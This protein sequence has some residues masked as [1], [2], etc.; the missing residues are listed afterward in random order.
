VSRHPDLHLLTWTIRVSVMLTW[1]TL[2]STRPTLLTIGR[3]SYLI[4]L[5][6]TLFISLPEWEAYVTDSNRHSKRRPN[7]Q[8]N[9]T[10]SVYPVLFAEVRSLSGPNQEQIDKPPHSIILHIRRTRKKR[11]NKPDRQRSTAQHSFQD[12]KLVLFL[13]PLRFKKHYFYS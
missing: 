6:T 5:D 11:T 7:H 2:M 12:F 9:Y 3:H 10:G 13:T 1:P 4:F 8:P